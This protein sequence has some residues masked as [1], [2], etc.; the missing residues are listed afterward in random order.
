MR[1]LEILLGICLSN[2]CQ[3]LGREQIPDPGPHLIALSPQE[4]QFI[5]AHQKT[6]L[7]YIPAIVREV[8]E[9]LND[10]IDKQEYTLE[11]KELIK[12][13]DNSVYIVQRAPAI[14]A[15]LG[16][17]QLLK[18]YEDSFPHG[19]I[20]ALCEVLYGYQKSLHKE[21]YVMQGLM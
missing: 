19:Y 18:K 13:V 5:L 1:V 2:F 4:I 17:L 10:F 14:K 15:T 6:E 11:L 12:S 8:L 3:S 21:E 16:A 20:D 7:A 9:V